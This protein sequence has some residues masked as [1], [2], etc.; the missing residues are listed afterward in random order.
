M[1]EHLSQD[2]ARDKFVFRKPRVGEEL[3]RLKYS[4]AF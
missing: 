3:S 1:H 2:K 4:R